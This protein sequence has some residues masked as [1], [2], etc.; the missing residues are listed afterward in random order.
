MIDNQLLE[1]LL[2]LRKKTMTYRA[3]HRLFSGWID[4]PSNLATRGQSKKLIRRQAKM[5]RTVQPTVAQDASNAGRVA[6]RYIDLIKTA[7]KRSFII[8]YT[9]FSRRSQIA[10]HASHSGASND[11]VWCL[12]KIQKKPKLST[13]TGRLCATSGELQRLHAYGLR[14]LLMVFVYRYIGNAS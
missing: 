10:L 3:T 11:T 8:K 2:V 13:R 12:L 7:K 6:N 9:F 4:L 1:L 5:A 14:R